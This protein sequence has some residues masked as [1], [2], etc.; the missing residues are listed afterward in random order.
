MAAIFP[1]SV[2]AT[3]TGFTSEQRAADTDRFLSLSRRAGDLRH[4][5]GPDDGAQRRCIPAALAD[6]FEKETGSVMPAQHGGQEVQVREVSIFRN[7]LFRISEPF[8]PQQE[9]KLRSYKPL[10]LGRLRFGEPPEHSESRA[11]QDLSPRCPLPGV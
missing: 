7:N 8:I 4:G 10:Y 1:P 5:D 3:G 11:L 2:I 9:Q 6:A